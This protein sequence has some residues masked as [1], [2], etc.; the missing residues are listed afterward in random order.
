MKIFWRGGKLIKVFALG[1]FPNYDKAHLR[2]YAGL[3]EIFQLDF[4]NDQEINTIVGQ[5]VDI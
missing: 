4:G 1:F 2:H 5:F 3:S